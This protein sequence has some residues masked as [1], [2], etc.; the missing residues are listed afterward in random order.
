MNPFKV[1]NCRL[2]RL[3]D[4]LRG[5]EYDR[6]EMRL[7]GCIV[8]AWRTKINTKVQYHLGYRAL[9]AKNF[10]EYSAAQLAEILVKRSDMLE[11]SV[12]IHLV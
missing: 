5:S 7:C 11:S 1:I 12:D 6:F 4:T 10:E 8:R 3:V 9:W 2:N